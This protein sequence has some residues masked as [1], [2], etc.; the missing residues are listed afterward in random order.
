MT[1][2][3]STVAAPA[4]PA[5]S[6]STTSEA[7]TQPEVLPKSPREVERQ[8]FKKETADLVE[9]D[10]KD[11]QSNGQFKPKDKSTNEEPERSAEA[12][13][14][15]AERKIW[16]LKVDG[17]EL[18]FD[19]TDEE[20]VKRAVQK[21]HAA[22]KRMHE[23]AMTRKQ[24]EK[25]IDLLKTNPRAVLEHPGL[26]LD[27]K[28]LAEQVIWENLQQQAKTPEEREREAER[29]ELEEYRK[30]K[31][32]REAETK[33][34]DREQLKEKYRQDWSK[35]FSEALDSARL[36]KT[37]WTV[38]RM[39]AYMRQ[40]LAKGHRHIQPADVVEFVREDW[41]SAQREMFA[42]LDGDDLIKTLGE[43]VAEKIRKAELRKF[44][45]DSPR[46][47]PAREEPA[48][49]RKYGSVEEMLRDQRRR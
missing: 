38:Q 35:K 6:Q 34:A 28:Q 29:A 21:T 27:L 37:D 14:T 31:A 24:A 26:G 44:Q 5:S 12:A 9:R 40:A 30:E 39:A 22:D 20:A 41:R 7:Q 25:F 43:D 13:K 11:R 3:A 32:R 36:P 47:D 46:S 48:E 2:P 16:K 33:E 8:R 42:S 18:D 10:K 17:Q 15:E 23:A 1:T 19:A 4:A 45:A 49:Q